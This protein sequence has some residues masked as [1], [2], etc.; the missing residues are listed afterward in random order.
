MAGVGGYVISVCCMGG[1]V[2]NVVPEADGVRDILRKYVE[3]DVA[4]AVEGLNVGNFGWSY[5]CGERD[6]EGI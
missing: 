2:G 4:S 1:D 6:G 5:W 3:E